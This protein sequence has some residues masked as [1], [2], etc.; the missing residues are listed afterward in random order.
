M[1]V[2]L[3]Y[4]TENKVEKKNNKTTIRWQTFKG[5]LRITGDC[6]MKNT[7]YKKKFVHINEF[8]V[9]WVIKRILFN[10]EP[11]RTTLNI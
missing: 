9:D 5:I 11:S 6:P 2:R 3:G 4:I 7:R 8:W 1:L 10:E